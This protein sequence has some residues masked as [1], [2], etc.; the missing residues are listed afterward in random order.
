MSFRLF[1]LCLAR[2]LYPRSHE[3]DPLIVSTLAESQTDL[4]NSE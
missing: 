4:C 3:S 1:P 2:A